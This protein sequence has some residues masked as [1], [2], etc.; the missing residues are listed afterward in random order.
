MTD[1][2]RQVY[3]FSAARTPIGRL[4]ERWRRCLPRRWAPPSFALPSPAPACRISRR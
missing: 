2:A 4:Q 3:I 1:E